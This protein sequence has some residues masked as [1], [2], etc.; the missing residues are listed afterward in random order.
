MIILTTS[1]SK[2]HL[3]LQAKMW[4]AR[5][6]LVL[7]DPAPA[8]VR[9]P[10]TKS[11]F[12]RSKSFFREILNVH[13]FS[14]HI[15]VAKVMRRFTPF[16]Q[17]EATRMVSTEAGL[18]LGVVHPSLLLPSPEQCWFEYEAFCV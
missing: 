15:F 9:R 6:C 14:V 12:E 5:P 8:T 10:S 18:G 4:I 1:S 16:L 3:E 17:T 2:H 11:I 7:G 13:L